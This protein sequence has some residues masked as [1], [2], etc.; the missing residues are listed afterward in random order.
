MGGAVQEF[1]PVGERKVDQGDGMHESIRIRRVGATAR[2]VFSRGGIDERR[3]NEL[4]GD[5]GHRPGVLEKVF[6]RNQPRQQVRAAPLCGGAT[7]SA[8]E[9]SPGN[10]A[11]PAEG[12][13]G[14]TSRGTNGDTNKGIG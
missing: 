1:V 11:I 6:A 3:F 12:A 8:A 14:G 13:H 4:R 10:D 9:R 2:H 5:A 7:D